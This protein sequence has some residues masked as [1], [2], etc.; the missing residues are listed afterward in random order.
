MFPSHV[1]LLGSIDG[2]TGSTV[3]LPVP[4][5][6]AAEGEVK[7]EEVCPGRARHSVR[8][9]PSICGVQRTARPT[10]M[11]KLRHYRDLGTPASCQHSIYIGPRFQ[12]KPFRNKKPRSRRGLNWLRGQDLNLGPSGYEP[13]EL[14]GCSTPRLGI[15]NMADTCCQR[16][17]FRPLFRMDRPHSESSSPAVS[18]TPAG[19][20]GRCDCAP[21]RHGP[22]QNRTGANKI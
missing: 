20:G 15:C 11:L 2:P 16:K 3:L 8:A 17:M 6:K 4:E 21:N 9:V 7:R 5:A 19:P 14:P 18:R 10:Q 13:D 22:T 1:H 12:G